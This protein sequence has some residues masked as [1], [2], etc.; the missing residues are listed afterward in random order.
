MVLSLSVSDS[1]R[2]PPSS[3]SGARSAAFFCADPAPVYGNFLHIVFSRL[4]ARCDDFHTNTL[5][6]CLVA[7]QSSRCPRWSNQRLRASVTFGSPSFCEK[8]TVLT[9]DLV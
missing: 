1:G 2:V 3:P 8:P 4:L 9:W 5:G 6:I 7:L